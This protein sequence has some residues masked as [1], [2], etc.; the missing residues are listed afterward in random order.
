MSIDVHFFVCKFLHVK[1]QKLAKIVTF[2]SIYITWVLSLNYT[3]EFKP[4][5]RMHHIVIIVIIVIIAM[6]TLYS[7][8]MSHATLILFCHASM[9]ISTANFS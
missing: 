9:L 2:P 3:K 4:H 8:I 6:L 5:T 1:C 7:S